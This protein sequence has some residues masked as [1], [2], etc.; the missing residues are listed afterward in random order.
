MFSRIEQECIIVERK[1]LR[2]KFIVTPLEFIDNLFGVA[3]SEAGA[4]RTNSAV[5][6]SH[7]TASRRQ[8]RREIEFVNE[9]MGGERVVVDM[10]REL[11]VI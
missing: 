6:A 2:P 3:L 8:D 7:R 5:G 4:D 10:D 11:G 1:V 9:V